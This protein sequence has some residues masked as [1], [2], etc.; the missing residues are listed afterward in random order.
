MSPQE[1]QKVLDKIMGQITGYQ[2]PYSLDQFL[3]KYAFD[4]RLP[5]K[6]NDSTTGQETW[7]QSMN[8]TKFITMDNARKRVEIDDFM[9]PKR[10][11]TSL[12]DVL[13]AWNEVNYV[14]TERQIESDNINESDNI[15]NSQYVFRSQDV[16]RSK[17]ILFSD[18]CL[19][20]EYAA[21]AQR[22]SNITYSV[23]IEDSKEVTGS[24]E[25]SWSGKITNSFFI[26]DSYDMY[27]CLF[28]SHL[29]GKQYCIA[30]MQFEEEEYYRIKDMM[31]KWILTP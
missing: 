23:R 22:S 28:C 3:Q 29:A 14:S 16:H 5:F 31:V 27:E 9:L 10:E 11:I 21:A 6:V 26:H 15:Y 25:V 20:S 24:F 17:N 4:V 2:N 19:D 8:P 30:N 18:T 13:A 1:A 7:A 12:E